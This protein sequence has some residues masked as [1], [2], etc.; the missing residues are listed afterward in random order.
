MIVRMIERV[1][2]RP[3]MY[4]AEGGYPVV[5]REPDTRW[6]VA[7]ATTNLLFSLLYR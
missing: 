2:W 3:D 6:F 1:A 5:V 7:Q 4:V